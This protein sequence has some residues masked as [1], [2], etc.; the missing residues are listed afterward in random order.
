MTTL[1]RF[2]IHSRSWAQGQCILITGSVYASSIYI[3]YYKADTVG[4]QSAHFVVT[5]NLIS[6]MAQSQK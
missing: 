6:R 4:R 3:K 1:L 5:I 2:V